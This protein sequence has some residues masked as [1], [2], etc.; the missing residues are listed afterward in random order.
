MTH[1]NRLL[2]LFATINLASI[3]QETPLWMRQPAIS[4]DG[5]T[6]VFCYLGDLWRVPVAGGDAVLFTT[7][8][9]TCSKR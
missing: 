1:R 2:L 8:R 4:P 3:A 6:I 9:H 7:W 5:T